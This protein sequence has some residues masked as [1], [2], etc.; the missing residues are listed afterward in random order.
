MN[1]RYPLNT[2][3]EIIID[4]IQN[5]M[6]ENGYQ[7]TILMAENPHHTDENS[8]FIKTLLDIY[9]SETGNKSYCKAIGGGTYVH[10][11]DGG[12]AVG[13]EFPNDE[14]NM[15]GDDEFI[16]LDSL[17]INCKMFARAIIEICGVDN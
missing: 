11:I 5:I 15:H 17:M 4:T 2:S 13:A 6:I 14:N 12:V 16:K 3:K 7:P 1:I 8:K 9:S 10:N